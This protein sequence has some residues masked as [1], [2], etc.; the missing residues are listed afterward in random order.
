MSEKHTHGL[1]PAQDAPLFSE[2]HSSSQHR[3]TPCP[4]TA[5]ASAQSEPVFKKRARICIKSVCVDRAQMQKQVQL[6]YDE[7]NP[8]VDYN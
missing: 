4:F 1:T 6:C 7:H 5:A 2:V 3:G 8:P